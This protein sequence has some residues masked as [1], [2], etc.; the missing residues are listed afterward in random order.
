MPKYTYK[1]KKGLEGTVEG[2][3]EAENYDAAVGKLNQQGL[4]LL[5]L[6]EAYFGMTPAKGLILPGKGRVKLRDLA[7]FS[8]QLSGLLDSGLTLFAALGAVAEQ[9]ENLLFRK[10]VEKLRDSIKEGK[11]F[12][13]SL[14]GYPKIFPKIYSSMVHAGEVS[15]AL[16]VVLSRLADFNEREEELRSRLQIAMAYP[17]LIFSVGVMAIAVLLLFVMPKLVGMFEDLGQ[18]L[19]LPTRIVI[20]VSNFFR[21]YWWAVVMAC[22]GAFFMFKKK[23]STTEGKKN[24]DRLKLRVPLIGDL[25][26]K[27]EVERFART[28]GVLLKNGVSIVKAMGVVAEIMGNEVLKDEINDMKEKISGGSSLS[29]EIKKSA[30]F[31]AYVKNLIAIGEESRVLEKSLFK[32]SDSYDREIDRAVKIFTSL[33]E[34]ILILIMGVVVSFIVVS[35]LLPIF[36]INVMMG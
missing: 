29:K 17:A 22:V 1:A 3:I 36:E 31:P 32:V 33:L 9:T 27:V 25:I 11:T 10:V 21:V 6:K 35:M 2:E 7:I 26:K 18:N 23:I 34:P 20:F 8:R 4:Y 14:A 19:P 30:V 5:D 13:E 16:D 28:L 24:F 15:G 12:S